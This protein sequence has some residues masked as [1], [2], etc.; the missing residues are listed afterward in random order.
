[1]QWV[2]RVVGSIGVVGRWEPWLAGSIGA[3][4]RWELW[5]VG[6]ISVASSPAWVCEF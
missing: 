6:L 1:M 5:L 2:A 3:M 4:G